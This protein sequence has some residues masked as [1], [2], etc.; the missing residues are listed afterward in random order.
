MKRAPKKAFFPDNETR[1]QSVLKRGKQILE[2]AIKQL[3][4]DI[5]RRS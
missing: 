4:F 2:Q 5:L 1:R 3:N